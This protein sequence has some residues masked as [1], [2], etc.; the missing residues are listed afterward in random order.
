METKKQVVYEPEVDLAIDAGD[1]KLIAFFLPQFHPI[2]ENNLW[3]GKGFT[4][5][6]NVTRAK[7]LFPGH[8]QPRFPADFGFYD[9]RLPCVQMEQIAMAKRH[10]IYGFCF[11]HY[12]FGGK[13]LL[14]MP[15]DRLLVTPEM[16]FPFCLCWANENWTRRWDGEDDHVLIAQNHS[17]E[18][19]LAFIA[20]VA[21]YFR[22]PRY[23]RVEGRPMLI[24]YRIQILPDARATA[25]RWRK[26]CREN[27]VGEIHLVMAQSFVF[28]DPPGDWGYDAAVEFPPHLIGLD[29]IRVEKQVGNDFSGNLYSYEGMSRIMM[30]H[31]WPDFTLYKTV[32]PDWDNT[33]RKLNAATVFTDAEPE[34][35]ARWLRRAAEACRAHLP[36]ERR[37]VFI[38]AWN[39]WAEGTYLEPDLGR[40]Y[41]LL[42]RTSRVL[43]GLGGT[44][45]RPLRMLVVSHDTNVGGAQILLLDLVGWL[46]GQSTIDL[47]LAA[48]SGGNIRERF[49]RQGPVLILDELPGWENDPMAVREDIRQFCGGTPDIVLVNS[50][51]GGQF[52]ALAV[53]DGVPI[54]TYL[55]ELEQSIIRFAGETMWEIVKAHTRM[56]LSASPAVTE[57]LITQRGV[58]PDRIRPAHAFIRQ[59]VSH[60][61]YAQF[62]CGAPEEARQTL[63]ER[64]GLPTDK[65]LVFGCGT[66]DWRKGPDI[67]YEAALILRELGD[68]RFQFCWLGAP[69][70]PNSDDLLEKFRDHPLADCVIFLGLQDNPREFLLAGDACFLSSRE[71][72]FPLAALEACECGLPIICFEGTGGIPGIVEKG[73]MGFVLSPEMDPADAANALV[74]IA[75][76]KMAAK[77][78]AAGRSKILAEHTVSSAAP[79]IL[80]HCR[81]AAGLP[82]AVSVVVPNYNYARYLPERLDSILNQT[83]QDI[84][85][86]VLDD[87]STDDSL[88]VLE[89]YR[90]IPYLRIVQ[91]SANSGNAFRQWK[92][93]IAL[94]RAPIVWIAEADD[95]SEKTFLE[96][97]LP[98]FRD[99][100]VCMA[101][102]ASR[103]IDENGV[104]DGFD[105]RTV[106]Y[107]AMLS[108]TRWFEDY[109]VEGRTEVLRGMGSRNT[110]LN[111]S[112]VLFRRPAPEAVDPS[113]DYQF[114]GDWIFYLSLLKDGNLAYVAKALNKHRRH[115]KSI[116]T[117]TDSNFRDL[118]S[119]FMRV[120]S[121]VVD[122]YRPD[123]AMID[124]MST[125]IRQVV[126]PMFPEQTLR[127]L[128]RYYDSDALL[129][130][131]HE[132]RRSERKQH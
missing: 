108:T 63:R 121:Y 128:T 60:D 129:E 8:Y 40:G 16:D 92:K 43:N 106:P 124:E 84:E 101:T 20:D 23:I 103:V 59:A 55:H 125:F 88:A 120:H 14:E 89:H 22:D 10:G 95:L 105:Y 70:E 115:P 21:K 27:G 54:V 111:A 46:R 74:R 127:D 29:T 2:P 91:N 110:I 80:A 30:D 81:Q 19:D 51:A 45:T 73:G 42:N 47:R 69:S 35:Y 71:D 104:D 62:G 82:P 25:D 33:A 68:E 86:I 100:D 12:W 90:H 18:D 119:E 4:E 94:A 72:P 26:W 24:V 50:V 130:R 93:G 61:A 96:E 99:P 102:C 98:A 132:L 37:F 58:E 53:F 107:L 6:R 113:I 1:V 131:C 97:L 83:M 34:V 28:R 13:R 11:H 9:L 65:I 52:H 48:L 79:R 75:D 7:P 122:L 56:F 39:E 116:S 17:P 5:W 85:I 77:L 38:N 114:S 36:P 126:L 15:V 67:F 87:A 57:N 117:E 49:E 76:E 109:V 44:P 112:S 3:W 66:I 31:P 32:S 64:L 123:E 78:G 118:L 41:T